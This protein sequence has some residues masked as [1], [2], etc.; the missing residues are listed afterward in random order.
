MLSNLTPPVLL[1][2][3]STPSPS[4]EGEERTADTPPQTQTM[5]PAASKPLQPPSMSPSAAQAAAA[6]AQAAAMVNL[7]SKEHFKLHHHLHGT[8]GNGQL[9][10]PTAAPLSLV[11]IPSR[12]PAAPLKSAFVR[13]EY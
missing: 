8:S 12:T 3:Q 11:K 6:A 7:F 10:P 4:E 1:R 9:T 2:H 5:P 13:S